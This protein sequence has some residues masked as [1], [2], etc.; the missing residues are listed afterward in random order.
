MAALEVELLASQRTTCV[1]RDQATKPNPN[2]NPNRN[3]TPTPRP[4]PNPN[5]NGEH[6]E[7]AR[8]LP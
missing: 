8:G 2:P 5:P 3:P 7:E 1:L 4:E 6:A